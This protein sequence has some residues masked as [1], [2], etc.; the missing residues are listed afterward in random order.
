MQCSHV[1]YLIILILK[2]MHLIIFKCTY[3]ISYKSI[4]HH[5]ASDALVTLTVTNSLLITL[6]CSRVFS[7]FNEITSSHSKPTHFLILFTVLLPFIF[8]EV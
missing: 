2:K 1:W 5:S 3:K 7:V 8:K 6:L 4:I